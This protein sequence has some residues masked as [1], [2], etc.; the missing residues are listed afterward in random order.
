M[1]SK[2]AIVTYFSQDRKKE[3]KREEIKM[4][5]SLTFYHISLDVIIFY[6]PMTL[7]SRHPSSSYKNKT[8]FIT[9]HISHISKEAVYK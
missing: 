5:N 4:I 8:V 6:K 7:L 2:N 1:D 9:L 3:K